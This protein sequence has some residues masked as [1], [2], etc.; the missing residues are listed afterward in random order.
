MVTMKL[1]LVLCDII[2]RSEEIISCL[3][4]LSTLKDSFGNKIW[5]SLDN[6]KLI[7]SLSLFL[8]TL[9]NI[10]P[11]TIFDLG[12]AFAWS[13]NEMKFQTISKLISGIFQDI[14]SNHTIKGIDI[15]LMYNIIMRP[16]S[17]EDSFSE[18]IWR[19]CCADILKTFCTTPRFSEEMIQWIQSSGILCKLLNYLEISTK[20]HTRFF[21]CALLETIVINLNVFLILKTRIRMKQNIQS[22]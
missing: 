16:L 14:I 9:A 2:G 19:F 17:G 20:N 3:R 18:N 21:S 7:R 4:S 1:T 10:T 5:N 6:T 15:H 12:S 13:E 11:T 8:W 22:S